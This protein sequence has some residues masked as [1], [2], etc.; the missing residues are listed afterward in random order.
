MGLHDSSTIEE[1]KVQ[2]K[3]QG[4]AKHSIVYTK[5][6]NMLSKKGNLSYSEISE[7]FFLIIL[8]IV[9]TT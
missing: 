7:V 3:P 6:K 1:G 2:I 8:P 5:P 4:S 9:L